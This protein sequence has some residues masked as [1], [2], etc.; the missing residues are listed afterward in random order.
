M[1]GINTNPQNTG[2]GG[3]PSAR[4]VLVSDS[5]QSVSSS[6]STKVAFQTQVEN[7]GTFV[8][9]DDTDI[10]VPQSGTYRALVDV[11]CSDGGGPIGVL[12]VLAGSTVIGESQAV[13]SV[14]AS[15]LTLVGSLT[16]AFPADES[17]GVSV[18]DTSAGGVTATQ[19]GGAV[20]VSGRTG[21]YAYARDVRSNHYIDLGNRYEVTG[22]TTYMMWVYLLGGTGGWQSLMCKP[23]SN[24]YE[25]L[26]G[27]D[28]G[29]KFYG[30]NG[31]CGG[32]T[33]PTEEWAHVALRIN[34]T[35]G[36]GTMFLNGV[37][38]GTGSGQTTNMPTGSNSFC[39]GYDPGYGRPLNAYVNDIQL[40][41]AALT[42]TQISNLY[43]YSHTASGTS[44]VVAVPGAP[45]AGQTFSVTG[46]AS[47][48]SAGD[49]ISAKFYHEKGTD[50]TLKSTG[51]MSRILVERL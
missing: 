25:W 10:A 8:V 2:G 14:P 24:N 22:S 3:G 4:V 23:G 51:A 35:T 32:G 9:T 21:G 27:S 6:S 17:S 19:N 37:V 44:M 49:K 7:V 47:A 15:A 50:A 36:D 1:S 20:I 31:N 34:R 29:M 48:L 13:P 40:Y 41:N 16:G 43:Q 12:Q 28:L 42:D 5:D 46:I 30:P 33:V 18:Y 38:V 45:A 26:I 11:L 39:V